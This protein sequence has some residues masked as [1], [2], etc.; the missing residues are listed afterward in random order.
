M[1]RLNTTDNK[2]FYGGSAVDHLLHLPCFEPVNIILIA[3]KGEQSYF[4]MAKESPVDQKIVLDSPAKLE[5]YSTEAL[6]A[7]LKK[8]NVSYA[9]ENSIEKDLDFQF[10][11]YKEQRR[12]QTLKSEQEFIQKL[13]DV[14]C[15]FCC[16][17]PLPSETAIEGEKLFKE[18]CTSCHGVYTKVVGPALHR[19]HK[20][21][22]RT[23][24][25]LLSFTKNSAKMIAEGD[26]LA[27]RIY[28]ENNKAAMNSFENLSDEEIKSIYT[29]IRQ[30]DCSTKDVG[31]AN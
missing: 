29:Y 17:P 1:Y 25:W 3:Y 26:P 12:Q 6:K 20:K 9:K 19:V 30:F 24:E 11:F 18:N 28:E 7:T 8:Y 10:K 14:V 4:A 16:V 31:G 5:A 23:E 2:I 21:E 13:H 15:F 27:L 22:G